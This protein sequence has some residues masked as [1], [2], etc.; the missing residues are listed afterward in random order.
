MLL[1][2]ARRKV[3]DSKQTENPQKPRKYSNTK[4]SQKHVS[5]LRKS[6]NSVKKTY[7]SKEFDS[8]WL[9]WQRTQ[10]AEII[11]KESGNSPVVV[12]PNA[13]VSEEKSFNLSAQCQ[14]L[15][16]SFR[17]CSLSDA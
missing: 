6:K 13:H 1:Y 12:L 15:E 16:N 4:K 9:A 14:F 11:K 10:A 5:C 8:C 3:N 7:I 17:F 2:S